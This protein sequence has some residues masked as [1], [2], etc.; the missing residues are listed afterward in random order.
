MRL[1][2]AG[3]AG[4]LAIASP[5]AA[6]APASALSVRVD[7]AEIAT[8]LGHK[9]TFRSTID[10]EGSTALSGVIAHLNVLSYDPGTYVDPEDWSSHRTMYLATLPPHAKRTITWRMQAVNDGTFAVYVAAVP[11]V[12]APGAPITG[13]A[14]RVDVAKRTTLNA[15]G[16]VPL[17]LGIPGALGLLAVALRVRRRRR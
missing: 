12:G 17:A 5:A 15:Q 8:R 3:L 6:A 1:W 4:L 2:L 10:N 7:R 13:P 9:F 16:I 14:I 11:R